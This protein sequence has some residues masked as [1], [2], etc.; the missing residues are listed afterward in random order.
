RANIERG[1]SCVLVVVEAKK[2]ETQVHAGGAVV[3]VVEDGKNASV[4]LN[5][6]D[7]VKCSPAGPVPEIVGADHLDRAHLEIGRVF[8]GP[9]A[10]PAVEILV[11][12]SS[13]YACDGRKNLRT[14]DHL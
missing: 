5:Q 8:V 10:G 4:A 12:G 3:R 2:I 7:G 11:H 13:D 1:R 14:D 6:I 9:L